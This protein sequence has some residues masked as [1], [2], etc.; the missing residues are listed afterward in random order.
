MGYRHSRDVAEIFHVTAAVRDLAVHMETAYVEKLGG[1]VRLESSD[2]LRAK[3]CL[4]W[5]VFDL[6]RIPLKKGLHEGVEEHTKET[7]RPPAA[8][9]FKVT[10]NMVLG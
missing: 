10:E 3:P 6:G 7:E 4:G 8:S 5:E 1:D 2:A 9:G